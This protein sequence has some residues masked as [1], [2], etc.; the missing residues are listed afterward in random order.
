MSREFLKSVIEDMVESSTFLTAM[1]PVGG[2]VDQVPEVDGAYALLYWAHSHSVM[3]S[4]QSWIAAVDPF[5]LDGL[6][7]RTGG[8]QAN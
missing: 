1:V 7:R 8:S 6:Q 2:H 3:A 5:S 4:V